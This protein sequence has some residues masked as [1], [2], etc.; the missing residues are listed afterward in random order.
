MPKRPPTLTGTSV[1]EL[2]LQL[3]SA[4]SEICDY[5]EE[6]YGVDGKQFKTYNTIDAN[7]KKIVNLKTPTASKDAVPKDYADG[8][9]NT[10][11]TIA[12]PAGTDPVADNASDT[13]TFLAGSDLVTITGNSATDSVSWNVG[14]S[15]DSEVLAADVAMTSADTFY[16]GPAL[17]LGVGTW[18]VIAT[19]TVQSD[20]NAIMFVTSKLWNGTTEG[21]ST[22]SALPA[23]GAGV[24]GIV[25]HTL[26]A[27]VAISS[28]TETWKCSS[29][30][31]VAAFNLLAST[32][33][34]I[35]TNATQ[36]MA[37]RVG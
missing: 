20:A 13:L 31:T 8:L 32:P 3:N 6:I 7:S 9:V 19:N 35:A 25:S 26:H 29:A 21:G 11:K 1:A 4:M 16:D 22:E 34:N 14:F 36:I 10:F 17:T 18:L 24:K 28:G 33:D 15:P 2:R 23:M 27:I 37:V 5:I 30:A 12:C